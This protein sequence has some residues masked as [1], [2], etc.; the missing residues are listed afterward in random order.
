MKGDVNTAVKKNIHWTFR[1]N[2]NHLEDECYMQN[3]CRQG[4][5]ACSLVEGFWRFERCKPDEYY[6]R[7]C[8]LRGKSR[9]ETEAIK[10]E[11]A[12]RGIEFV[13]QYSFWAIFRSRSP[14][15]LYAPEEE[16]AVCKNIFAPMPIGAVIGW[17][18]TLIGVLLALY[19]S[20]WAA[21]LALLAA[22][23]AGIV[24]YCGL[25]YWKLIQN[26]SLRE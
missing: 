12:G 1:Y 10:T 15:Q 4:W 22:V 18:V 8:Y 11:Y 23:Y 7:I 21:F 20:P 16:L 6:Y 9:A 19:A 14:F 24:T 17:L 25:S 3:M 26:L 5:A 13:S 2:G